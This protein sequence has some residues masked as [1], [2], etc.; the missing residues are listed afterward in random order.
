M[1]KAKEVIEK[2]KQEIENKLSDLRE[3]LDETKNPQTEIDIQRKISE[4]VKEREKLERFEKDFLK[5]DQADH[6]IVSI[7]GGKDSSVL[8]QYA[9]DNFPK[10][11]L[12][13]VHAKIDIDWKETIPV[14]EA[15][16]KHFGLLS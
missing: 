9:V 7:S 10:E 13:C 12:V 4:L 6:V 14:V 5:A 16:C 11:K 2:M 1:N 15:Q 8:M 3:Q